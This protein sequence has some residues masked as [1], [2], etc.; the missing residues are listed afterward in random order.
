MITSHPRNVGRKQNYL[1]INKIKMDIWDAY[2]L[3]NQ[4]LTGITPSYKTVYLYNF[5][6]HKSCLNTF[7][8]NHLYDRNI[9]GSL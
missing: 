5:P 9:Y 7:K 1:H 2:T 3:K 4:Q 8:C 6:K